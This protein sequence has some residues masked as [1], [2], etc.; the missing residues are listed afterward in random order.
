MNRDLLE[1]AEGQIVQLRRRAGDLYDD[2]N[3]TEGDFLVLTAELIEDLILPSRLER[4]Q[5]E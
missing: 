5:D 3:W 2:E 4:T 1:R